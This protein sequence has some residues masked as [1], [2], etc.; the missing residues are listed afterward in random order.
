MCAAHVMP[1]SAGAMAVVSETVLAFKGYGDSWESKQA[2]G[3]DKHEQW[4]FAAGDLTPGRLPGGGSQ[5]WAWKDDWQ[6][7]G[8]GEQPTSSRGVRRKK[9]VRGTRLSGADHEGSALGCGKPLQ[10]E[11]GGSQT[12]S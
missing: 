3:R 12:E 5:S 10:L 4:K 2:R 9:A 1:P 6:Q 8:D 11:H 7:G